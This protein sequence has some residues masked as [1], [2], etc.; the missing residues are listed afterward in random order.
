MSKDSATGTITFSDTNKPLP[1]GAE[2]SAN[3]NSDLLSVLTS[4]RDVMKYVSTSYDIHA[5]NAVYIPPAQAMRNAADE[6]ER[7]DRVIEEARRILKKL[8][9]L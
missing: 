2:T 7:K 6:L 9:H 4:L 3:Q 1:T 5:V 8:D